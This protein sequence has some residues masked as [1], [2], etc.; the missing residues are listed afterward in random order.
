M[1]PNIISP[2]CCAKELQIRTNEDST[3]L[4]RHDYYRMKKLP[5]MISQSNNKMCDQNRRLIS[6]LHKNRYQNQS[7]ISCTRN[8]IINANNI[9]YKHKQQLNNYRN[10]VS[11]FTNNAVITN[12][13]EKQSISDSDCVLKYNCATSAIDRLKFNEQCNSMNFINRTTNKRF[14]LSRCTN[15]YHHGSSGFFKFWQV[16]III[17]IGLICTSSANECAL[18]LE[19]PGRTLPAGDIVL[20]YGQSLRILCMLNMTFSEVKYPGKNA[21]DLT[22]FH[23]D[24][25]FEPEYLSVINETTIELFIDKP[26]AS[27][28]MYYCKM[29]L[30]SNYEEDY[31]TVCLNDVAI[32]F[33]PEM[34]E[35]FTCVSK[36]WENLL[37]SWDPVENH[38]ETE[39]TLL[40]K[41]QGRSGKRNAFACPA[42]IEKKNP[43]NTCFWDVSTNPIYR[44]PYDTYYFLIIV[45]N[46]L[47]NETFLVTFHHFEHVI[48]AKPANLSVVSK[49]IDSAM[50][51]WTIPFPMVNFPVGLCHRIAVQHQWDFE[52]Q[53]QIIDLPKNLGRNSTV[54]NLY[55]NLTGLEHANT[56]Y[57][58]RVFMKSSVAKGEDRWSNFSHI[59]F[60]TLPRLPG[61][62]ARTD[63]GSFEIMENKEDR[64]VY[65]YWQAIPLQ[66][67]NGDNFEYRVDYI[68]M[69]GHKVSIKPNETTRTYAK[70]KAISFK[71]YRFVISTLNVVGFH[72]EKAVIFIPSRQ[73]I[74]SEPLAFTKIAFNDGLYEL[75]WKTP[76]RNKKITNYTIFWCDNDRDRPYQCTGYLD[77]IHVPKNTTV[78]NIT[79]PDPRKVY[80]FAISSNTPEGSSGMVWASCTVIHDGVIGKMKSVWITQRGSN[81]I[82]VSWK[83]DCSDRIG[84]VEG[85][86][87]YYCPIVSPRNLKCKEPKKHTK[88]PAGPRTTSG[89]I[90]NLKPYT[91]YMINVAVVTKSGE[92]LHS[93]PLHDTTFEAAPS[94][95]PQNVQITDVTNTTLYVS[96]ES[97]TAMNGVLRYYEVHYSGNVLKVEES[98]HVLLRDLLPFKNYSIHVTACTV[99]CSEPSPVIYRLTEIGKPGKIAK[100]PTVRFINS[101][102]MIIM[103]S[104]PF[105]FGGNLDYYQISSGNGEI[106][107]STKMEIQLPIPD[108]KINDRRVYYFQ[109][110]AVNIDQNGEHF[111]GPWSDPGENN[112][113]NDGSSNRIYTII[114]I[115]CGMCGLVFILCLAYTSRRMWLK[116]KDMQD[117]QVEMPPGLAPCEKLLQKIS[118]EQ[119][120][121]QS[122]DSSHCSGGQESVT[123]SLTSDSHVSADSGTEIDPITISQNKLLETPITWDTSSLR[124]RNVG[125]TRLGTLT[126]S[127]KWDSYGKGGKLDEIIDDSILARSTPNLTNSPGFMMPQQTWSSTGYISMPSSEELS[128]NPSPTPADTEHTGSYSA[129]GIVPS[130]IPS[131]I[132]PS[133]SLNNSLLNPSKDNIKPNVPYVSLASL[134]KK[135]LETPSGGLHNF[136]KLKFVPDQSSKPYVQSGLIDNMKKSFDMNSP[137]EL[138]K[139]GS[140]SDLGNKHGLVPTFVANTTPLQ[141]A[142]IKTVSKPYVTVGSTSENMLAAKLAM[143]LTDDKRQSEVAVSDNTHKPYVQASTIFQL[144]QKN[145]NDDVLHE[146]KNKSERVSSSPSPIYWQSSDAESSNLPELDTSTVASKVQNTPDYTTSTETLKANE[147]ILDK[148]ISPYVQHQ[149]FEKQ[150]TPPSTSVTDEQYSKV[151]VVPHTTTMP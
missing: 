41:L 42:D 53:W 27:R 95:P 54:K 9:H 125:T 14:S 39:I 18:G 7:T 86:N 58:I 30:D 64:D 110:R 75:S 113:Y 40:F 1:S 121:R 23:G 111:I 10:N 124:Q 147:T 21:S 106:Q 36:N 137:A 71:S 123:S 144:N 97:P 84:N 134:E 38:V 50:I 151:A 104:K 33:R 101:T 28:E 149:R 25:I 24:D 92:G 129:V 99:E 46:V 116:C 31:E 70:F 143:R 80:Q 79:V 140:I 47:G 98:T 118:G 35:N 130:V 51:H 16:A 102:H 62:S 12:C 81:S 78:Y 61:M 128:S 90:T 55:Y 57:D 115:I 148:K 26:P 109:V 22:F 32:G 114:W 91:T 73:E 107:N 34:P 65:L 119:H 69:N 13:R 94:T 66:L 139:K 59:T 150:I 60:R 48:P 87:I 103:W 15:Y 77:W 126:D 146:K 20:E 49:T 43:P 82:T 68:E 122:S 127:L 37:C 19:T 131:K 85:F 136:D 74:P 45:T 6:H 132:D 63:I 67:E 138:L 3:K 17:F 89:V 56:V 117:I 76:I 83:L 4:I 8:K 93:N 44:Q 135:L 100:I 108:C 112:C 52:K 72:P 105:T 142:G 11:E 88:I 96:W 133:K 141:S 120:I 145:K 2:L 29:R 5:R